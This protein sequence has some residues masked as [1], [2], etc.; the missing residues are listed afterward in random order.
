MSVVKQK[1]TDDENEERTSVEFGV[2]STYFSMGGGKSFIAA[3]L[4]IGSVWVA[5]STV[6]DY[7][8]GY[9]SSQNDQHTRLGFYYGVLALMIAFSGFTILA[10][11]GNFMR[12]G[13]RVSRTVHMAASR[14]VLQAPINLFFDKTPT[15]RILNRFSKD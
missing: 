8:L 7:W 13:L 11:V 14:R 2:Y 10:R 15:G 9:S 3:A 1:I 12:A 4:L 5:L 6:F